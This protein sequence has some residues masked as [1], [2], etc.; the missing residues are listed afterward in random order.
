MKILAVLTI[1][2]LLAVMAQ[3]AVWFQGSFDAAKAQ[4]QL[5][6]KLILVDFYS[7]G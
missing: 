3:S 1:I 4:A 5:E 2:L 7:D 6:N